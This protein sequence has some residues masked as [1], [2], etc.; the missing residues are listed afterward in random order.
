MGAHLIGALRSRAQAA[1]GQAKTHF[2]KTVLTIRGPAR[3]AFMRS[4]MRNIPDRLVT[5]KRRKTSFRIM[6]VPSRRG[7]SPRT[8]CMHVRQPQD[9]S[10]L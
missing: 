1:D 2:Q 9:R 3:R 5:S 6:K 7:H 8:A 10:V 4:S